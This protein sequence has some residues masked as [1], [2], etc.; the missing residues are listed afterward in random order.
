VW[1]G[2]DNATR[3]QETG[4]GFKMPRYDWSDAELAETLR[5]C[6]N[7]A[8]MRAKLAS[9]AAHMQAHNGPEKAARILHGLLA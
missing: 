5:A 8:G 6:M 7:D 2:H 9:T 4:H 3:V 1:D